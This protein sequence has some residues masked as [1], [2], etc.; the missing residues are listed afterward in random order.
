MATGDA[1]A[2]RL[3]A[4]WIDGDNIARPWSEIEDPAEAREYPRTLGP[5]AIEIEEED[6]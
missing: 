2:P 6:E 1:A 5:F 3:E 4:V